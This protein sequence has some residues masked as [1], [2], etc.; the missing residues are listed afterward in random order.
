MC[1]QAGFSSCCPHLTSRASCAPPTA[2]PT[3]VHVPSSHLDVRLLHHVP[4]RDVEKEV[5]AALAVARGALGHRRVGRVDEPAAVLFVPP[6]GKQGRSRERGNINTAAHVIRGAEGV[7]EAQG[8]EG[9]S[10]SGKA[11]AHHPL[12]YSSSAAM[13]GAEP[14]YPLAHT[15]SHS[16]THTT[17]R[18]IRTILCCRARRRR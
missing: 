4:N 17:T 3:A 5:G 12:L 8:R 10:H 16:R 14:H 13:S 1:C 11:P 18:T 15:H 7:F 2:N 6:P 9:C